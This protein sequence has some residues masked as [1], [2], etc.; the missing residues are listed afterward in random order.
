MERSTL[1]TVYSGSS[2][3]RP[4]LMRSNV[5]LSRPLDKSVQNILSP[6]LTDIEARRQSIIEGSFCKHYFLDYDEWSPSKE[7]EPIQS[8][9]LEAEESS[10]QGETNLR[11]TVSKLEP[12]KPTPQ[13]VRIEFTPAPSVRPST[14]RSHRKDFAQQTRPPRHTAHPAYNAML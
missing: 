12:F 5:T 11:K 1:P 14:T 8:E 9:N 2:L 13:K 6:T 10:R 3:G 7:T 4:G